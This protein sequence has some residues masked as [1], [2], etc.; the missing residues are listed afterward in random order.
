[1]MLKKAEN[2]LIINV[3][4]YY[5]ACLFIRS[6]K[7]LNMQTADL[8]SKTMFSNVHPKKFKII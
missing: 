8:V 7:K 2:I 6:Q 1:M 3:I 5:I 4:N